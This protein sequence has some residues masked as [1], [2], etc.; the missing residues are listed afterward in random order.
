M[1][2][3]VTVTVDGAAL[4]PG[5][6]VSI[7]VDVDDP[8]PL[9]SMCRFADWLEERCA[10]SMSRPYR[11]DREVRARIEGESAVVSMLR[12]VIANGGEIPRE[13]DR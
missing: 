3:A 7:T 5:A 10:K 12:A 2:R 6:S 13:W 1:S 8:Q 4:I 11:G 9:D